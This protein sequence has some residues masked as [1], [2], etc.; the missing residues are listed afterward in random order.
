M[1]NIQLYIGLALGVSLTIP[2]LAVYLY[3]RSVINKTTKEL[4]KKLTPEQIN[5]LN[6]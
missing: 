6:L 5:K 2:T 1:N 3:Y 4:D